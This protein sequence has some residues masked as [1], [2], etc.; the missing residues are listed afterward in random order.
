M[1]SSNSSHALRSIGQSISAARTPEA[2]LEALLGGDL[3]PARRGAILVFDGRWEN[4]PPVSL[5]VL[6]EWPDSTEGNSLLGQS[7]NIKDY[8]LDTLYQRH[9]H[10]NVPGDE[11]RQQ[12]RAYFDGVREGSLLL[13]PLIANGSWYGMLAI[14]CD[15]LYERNEP[16][17]LQG[18]VDQVTASIYTMLL[19]ESEAEA[20]REAE[21]S[22]DLRM[23]MLATLADEL[24]TPIMSIQGF[25]GALLADDVTW[26]PVS[27]RD[28]IWTI[29]SEANRMQE[30]I[31]HL[32]EHARIEAGTLVVEMEIASLQQVMEIAAPRLEALTTEHE[33]VISIPDD[34]PFLNIDPQRVAQA[35]TNLVSNAVK[36]SPPFSRVFISARAEGETVRIA[37]SDEGEGIAPEDVEHVF[38]PF[39]QGQNHSQTIVSG[40][41][42]GLTISKALIEAQDG[43]VHICAP[44]NGG[45]TVCITLPIV[46]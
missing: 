9:K 37:V 20:H 17:G 27:Q 18:L 36:Y 23:Q 25:V 4:T 6:A 44:H 24:R 7:Y 26:D 28:F 33:L 39:Y 21:R 22:A 32:V 34:L 11:Q 31:E 15:E 46:S 8:G 12:T 3:L 2:M 41:G 35:I 5:S 42:L 43:T 10:L 29:G 38:E 16:A 13:F 14:H 19:A 45:A 1:S 40:L 30:L